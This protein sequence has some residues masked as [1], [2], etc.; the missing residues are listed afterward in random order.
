MKDC[1]IISNSLNDYFTSTA[2]TVNDGKLNI[3]KLDI[4]HPMEY[5][6]QTFKKPFPSIKLKYTSTKEIIKIITFL[7]PSNSHGY[8]ASSIKI[9]K[10][11]SQFI[12]SPLTYICNQSLSTGIFP[13]CCNCNCNLSH[14]P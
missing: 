9:L 5:V 10:A 2:I 8:N 12:I 3:G 11:S 7:K 14:L 1:Q 6:H 4:N 13:S